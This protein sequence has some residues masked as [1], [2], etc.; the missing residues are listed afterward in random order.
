MQAQT[1]AAFIEYR[2]VTEDYFRVMR[3]IPR[4]PT[5]LQLRPIGTTIRLTVENGSPEHE[6]VEAFRGFGVPFAEIPAQ[7]PPSPG[8]RASTRRPVTAGSP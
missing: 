2:Q 1:D 7:S 6:A 8:R 3:I 5:A 4:S